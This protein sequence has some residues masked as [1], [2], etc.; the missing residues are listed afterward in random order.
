MAHLLA[1]TLPFLILG[2]FILVQGEL[3]SSSSF[4]TITLTILLIGGLGTWLFGR[5]AIHL[6]ASGLI[7]GYIGFLL[8]NGYQVQT[9]LTIGFAIVVLVLY[10]SQLWSMLPSSSENKVSWEG[11]LFGF[12]GGVVAGTRPDLL[13]TASERIEQLLRQL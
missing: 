11:H 1:N 5:N 8:I 2:W 10:G 9:L 13:A 3:G 7:F 4:Y 12:I 6:G